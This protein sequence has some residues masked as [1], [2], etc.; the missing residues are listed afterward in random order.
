MLKGVAGPLLAGASN[1]FGSRFCSTVELSFFESSD[2]SIPQFIYM[3]NTDPRAA[4]S[5]AVSEAPGVVTFARTVVRLEDCAVGW[6][7]YVASVLLSCELM[8]GTTL[9]VIAFDDEVLPLLNVAV[10]LKVCVPVVRLSTEKPT[11]E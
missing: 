10:A 7:A 2:G 3:L 9:S 11:G 4:N 6:L 1:V 5:V 8:E